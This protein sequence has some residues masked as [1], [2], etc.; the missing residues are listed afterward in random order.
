[1]R[2]QAGRWRVVEY[3]SD[4]VSSAG[5]PQAAYRAWRA[6]LLKKNPECPPGVVPLKG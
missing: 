3:V 5:D 4:E 6:A 2:H 1:M